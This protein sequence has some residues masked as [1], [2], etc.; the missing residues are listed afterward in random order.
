[1]V[2]DR[3]GERELDVPVALLRTQPNGSFIVV[4]PGSLSPDGEVEL[5]LD[6]QPEDGNADDVLAELREAGTAG[7]MTTKVT[8]RGAEGQYRR[9][10]LD[11]LLT[12]GQVVSCPEGRGTRWWATGSAPDDGVGPS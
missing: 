7:L 11:R 10:P 2:K 9:K 12:S 5:P 1:M 4:P 6:L 3:S 8:G